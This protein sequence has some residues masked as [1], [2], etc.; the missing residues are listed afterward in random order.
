MLNSEQSFKYYAFIS[1][2]HTDK[3]WGDWLHK[4]LETYRVPKHLIGKQAR[5]DIIPSRISPIF[6]DREELPTSSDLGSM[7]NNALK[8]SRYLIVI[9]SPYSAKSH[10][11]NE[12][13]LAFKRFKRSNRILCIIVDGEPNA[14]DKPDIAAEECFPNALK[15][16]LGT[17]NQL[18]TIRTEPIAAD[19]RSGKD[20]KSDAKLKLIAGILGI[21]F[22]ELKQRELQRRQKRLLAI[23]VVSISIA[24]LTIALAITAFIAKNEAVYQKQLAEEARDIAQKNLAAV[25]FEKAQNAYAEQKYNEAA[26]LAAEAWVK[27]PSNYYPGIIEDENLLTPLVGIFEANLKVSVSDVVAHENILF[28][29]HYDNIIRKWDL[30]SKKLLSQLEGHDDKVRDI[31]LSVDGKKLFSASYD[32][33]IKVWDTETGKNNVTFNDQHSRL[34]SV[35]VSPDNILVASGDENGKVSVLD[36][37]TGNVVRE[38]N[39]TVG[40]PVMNLHFDSTEKHLISSGG[41]NGAITIWS[42]KDW[43]NQKLI[44]SAKYGI[45][46]F[47]LFSDDKIIA[48]SAGDK[49]DT[50]N[51]K[52]IEDENSQSTSVRSKDSWYQDVI[53]N[54]N[55]SLLV[56]TTRYGHLDMLDLKK[57]KWLRSI[58]AHEVAIQRATFAKDDNFLVSSSIDGS[59]RIWDIGVHQKM[60]SRPFFGGKERIYN[61]AINDDKQFIATGDNDGVVRVFNADTGELVKEWHNPENIIITHVV[62]VPDSDNLLVSGVNQLKL[63]SLTGDD[64]KSYQYSSSS[65]E[66]HIFFVSND[67]LI[68][69]SNAG[70]IEIYNLNN[71]KVVLKFD[72]DR[73]QTHAIDVNDAKNIIAVGGFEASIDLWNLNTESL[74]SSFKAHDYS[75]RAVIFDLNNMLITA[76]TD[77]VIKYWDTDNQKLIREYSGHTARIRTLALSPDKQYIASGGEDTKV[78]IWNKMTGELLQTIHGPASYVSDIK[79]GKTNNILYVAYFDGT[80]RKVNLDKTKDNPAQYLDKI[81]KLTGLKVD[82]FRIVTLKLSEWEK[83]KLQE[84]IH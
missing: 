52:H 20:G 48:Y 59:I 25:L 27:D 37:I 60:L 31:A 82:G 80:I 72:N 54:Q 11:V 10:W 74:Q 2:S 62:F 49:E 8:E 19:A 81:R 56:A 44:A 36:L 24:M 67:K 35:A 5:E 21:G 39:S 75:V 79:Y 71:E 7:I 51:F 77:G 43:K 26:L 53:I 40:I 45:W 66:P 12:E 68:R 14:T 64:E 57:M 28:S 23:A 18:T 17:D 41:D 29:S 47:D 46:G 76:G 50:I 32:G 73:T 38:L 33:K 42:T 9:C 58:F 61:M 63:I 83:I 70:V 30:N 65:D 34:F 3:K 16:E 1:Y 69:T 6:R 84:T 55:E 4:A 22:N 78:K 15:F 13:I